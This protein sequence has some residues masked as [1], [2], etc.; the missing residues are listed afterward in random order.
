MRRVDGDK[1]F[2]PFAVVKSRADEDS[3]PLVEQ[4]RVKIQSTVD[5]LEDVAVGADQRVDRCAKCENSIRQ[6]RPESQLDV[7]AF[8]DAV[9]LDCYQTAVVEAHRADR[10]AG[11]AEESILARAVE[12]VLGLVLQIRNTKA[13]V[14][15]RS[16]LAAGELD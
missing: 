8:H 12:L 15:A 9:R 1:H 2:V 7:V 11:V 6:C 10:L 4:R 5:Q 14:L 13:V 3:F 16:G